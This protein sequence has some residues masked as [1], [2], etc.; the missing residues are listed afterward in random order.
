[1]KLR[2]KHCQIVM[3]F[4]TFEEIQKEN[5]IQCWVTVKGVNHHFNQLVIK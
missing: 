1:M 4:E 3:D 5:K 2:C